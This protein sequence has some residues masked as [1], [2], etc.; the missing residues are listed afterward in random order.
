MAVFDFEKARKAYADRWLDLVSDCV[1][2][3]EAGPVATLLWEAAVE[4]DRL[5][6]HAAEIGW[7]QQVAEWE[8][9]RATLPDPQT[10]K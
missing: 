6:K 2:A 3:W 1:D 4:A 10:Q 7:A 5:G 8:A 9:W